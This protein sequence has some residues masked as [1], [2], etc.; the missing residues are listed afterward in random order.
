MW[1]PDLE[2]WRR[3][4]ESRLGSWLSGYGEAEA[5]MN[6][7]A[8]NTFPVPLSTYMGESCQTGPVF[9][10]YAARK[11]WAFDSIYWNFLD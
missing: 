4:Y 5:S 1:S 8:Y 6:A 10:S 9:L 2:G 11:S 7:S 3:T